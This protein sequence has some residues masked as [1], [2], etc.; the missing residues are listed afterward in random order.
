MNGRQSLWG[1][2]YYSQGIYLYTDAADG[3]FTPSDAYRILRY[4]SEMD[5]VS[6][7]IDKELA[8]KKSGNAGGQN[9]APAKAAPGAANRDDRLVAALLSASVLLVG[10]M[11]VLRIVRKQE[12]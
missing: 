6:A 4:S 5:K 9:S 1:R 3:K 10:G 2:I 11:A 7:E 12:R 8:G